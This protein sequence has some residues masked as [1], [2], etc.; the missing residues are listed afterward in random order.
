MSFLL[1]RLRVF[2]LMILAAGSLLADEQ[3]TASTNVPTTDLLLREVHYDGKL[4]DTQARFTVDID[5]ESPGKSESSITL[6][7]GD[8]A[9]M[10]TK[11]PS[12]LRMVR[13]GRQ[14]RL[15]ASQPGSYRV[16][17]DGLQVRHRT[18]L[19]DRPGQPREVLGDASRH[20]RPD[21]R[22]RPANP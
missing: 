11:L 20:P 15:V 3:K 1:Y 16:K 14:Y 2:A 9:V 13:E 12:G 5:A 4:S 19:R 8:V 17:L 10:P 22:R 6:F 21:A 18:P 7:D